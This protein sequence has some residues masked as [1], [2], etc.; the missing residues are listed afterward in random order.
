MFPHMHITI[1]GPKNRKGENDQL[2][3]D[4]VSKTAH[5]IHVVRRLDIKKCKIGTCKQMGHKQKSSL[6]RPTL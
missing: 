3:V 4:A 2:T 5:S 6:T 1:K